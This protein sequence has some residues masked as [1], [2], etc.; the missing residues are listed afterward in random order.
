MTVD[1]SFF[2]SQT[3]QRIREEGREAGIEEGREAGR[4]EVLVQAV[5]EVLDSRGIRL[6]SA[7]RQRIADCT[8]PELLH[9]WFRRSLA[10]TVADDLFAQPAP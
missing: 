9:L 10:A 2:R 1:L 3:S 6:S 4:A 5:L 8:E 7:E